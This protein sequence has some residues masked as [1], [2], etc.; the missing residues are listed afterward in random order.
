MKGHYRD[1]VNFISNQG[2]LENVK[3]GHLLNDTIEWQPLWKIDANVV[4]SYDGVTR[5]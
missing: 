4:L 3:P 5:D 2:R 1:F